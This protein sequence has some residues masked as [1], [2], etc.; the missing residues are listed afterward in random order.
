M[1]T[2]IL[3]GA[4][5]RTQPILQR[6]VFALRHRV[7]VDTLGWEAIRNPDGLETDLFDT[8]D[9]VHFLVFK[10]RSEAAYKTITTSTDL[11]EHLE[12]A[13]YSRLLAT[14]RPH[15]LSDVYP[16]LLNDKKSSPPRGKHIWEWTRTTAVPY[17][18]KKA[19]PE[20]DVSGLG[21]SITQAGRVLFVA[22]VEWSLANEINTLSLQ[23]DPSFGPIVEAF[24][25]RVELL[26]KPSM[27]TENQ[28]V[29]PLLMH[30]KPSTPNTMRSLFKLVVPLES[31]G[32]VH[33]AENEVAESNSRNTKPLTAH[34]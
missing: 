34:L 16:H 13:A 18:T 6:R 23:C 32:F 7:F 8:D 28:A 15:L 25:A 1:T 33:E 26:G 22:I 24:G 27:T 10:T 20:N 31:V 9:A 4:E 17:P 3:T 11:F 30:I 19:K 14:T 12:L 29:V 5:L 21:F 2:I